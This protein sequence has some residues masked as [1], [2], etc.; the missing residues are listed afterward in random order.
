MK[1][2][3]PDMFSNS[4]FP[5]QAQG[6][7]WFLVM[8]SDLVSTRGDVSVVKGRRIGAAPWVGMWLRRLLM[9]AGLDPQR[10]NVTIAPIPGANA[11]TNFGVAAAQA[12]EDR[13]IDGFWANGMGA[14]IAGMLR[15]HN[16]FD[17]YDR[18]ADRAIA[19]DRGGRNTRRRQN[20]E[21]VEARRGARRRG[22]P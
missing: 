15:L 18:P 16:G 9:A 5:A 19:G 14:E 20:A 6:M 2:A 8:R 3:V 22:W 4:Y 7:Y 11:G 13:R 21:D 12:L 10:D 1:L 17:R